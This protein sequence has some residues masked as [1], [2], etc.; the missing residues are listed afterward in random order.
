MNDNQI[1]KQIIKSKTEQELRESLSESN[2]SF[3]VKTN[4][5]KEVL[6]NYQNMNESQKDSFMKKGWKNE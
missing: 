3:N 5:H 1:I 4:I 2:N 6:D